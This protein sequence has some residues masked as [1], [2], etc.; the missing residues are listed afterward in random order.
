[1]AP[2]LAPPTLSPL[3]SR[4][5][6]GFPVFLPLCLAPT[7][8]HKIRIYA[9]AAW[10]GPKAHPNWIT[11]S[12]RAIFHP[13]EKEETCNICTEMQHDED[14]R[15]VW[16][17]DDDDAFKWEI[18]SF[19]GRAPSSSLIC[20]TSSAQSVLHTFSHFT[21]NGVNRICIA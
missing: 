9:R 20:L 4:S 17:A 18:V 15:D 6:P 16:S 3:S 12:S 10:F 21:F 14:E 7:A 13:E 2:P 8:Q 11:F 5:S 1:M 19:P